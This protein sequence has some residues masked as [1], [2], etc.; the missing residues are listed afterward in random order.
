LVRTGR[1]SASDP[2]IQ[3]MPRRG[4][5]REIFCPSPGH[6][7]LAV[8]Y[9]AIELVTLAA[10]CEARY[11]RSVLADVIREGRD[12]HA[13]TAAIL[14]GRDPDE[15]LLFRKSDPEQFKAARQNAKA[16]NFGLPGGLGPKSLV[17][18]AHRSYRVSMTLEQATEFRD[19]MITEVYP[20]W[21]KYLSDDSMAILAHNLETTVEECWEAIGDWSGERSGSVPGF[22][23]RVVR[24]DV[25]SRDGKP[26]KESSMSHVWTALNH[27][28][29]SEMLA[30][31][32]SKRE[33][34]EELKRLLFHGGVV[35]LTGRIR[36]RVSFCQ[37]RNTPFQ[38]LAAD[39]AKLALWRL[40]R[41]G[42]RIV[43]FIHDEILVELPDEGGYVSREEVDRVVDIMCEEM[44]GVLGCDLP[45]KGEATLSTCWSKDAR[46]IERD[47][48]VFPWQPGEKSS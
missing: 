27:L 36:G 12:P 18:Y 46:L 6:H 22:V 4:G 32:L 47:G 3:Q 35:T 14:L 39:G 11:G 33:G 48:K 2:N 15:F 8:D 5:F 13:Y 40:M 16:L 23:R 41:E 34:S 44:R 9:A 43:G 21:Q 10:V 1:V 29:N 31:P 24:G 37:A 38:G 45:V 42:F 7:L 28:N 25:A 19:R 26:Y 20:E 30:P 17:A